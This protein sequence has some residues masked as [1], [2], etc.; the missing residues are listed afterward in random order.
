MPSAMVRRF[1]SSSSSVLI[2][3]V[4]GK[5]AFNDDMLQKSVPKYAYAE[6]SPYSH[7]ATKRCWTP[8]RAPTSSWT[9]RPLMWSRWR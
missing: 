3:D 7:A 6:P 9:P 5:Y 1:A 4:F 8:G 2:D